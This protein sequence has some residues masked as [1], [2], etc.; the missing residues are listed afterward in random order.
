MKDKAGLSNALLDII[1][2]VALVLKKYS[3]EIVF[4]NELAKQMGAIAGK[5]CFEAICKSDTACNFCKTSD[6]W[7]SGEKQRVETEYAGKFWEFVWLPYNDDL[8]LHYLFDRTD[9]RWAEEKLRRSETT[10][11]TL[12][13]LPNAA[14]FLLDRNGICLDTNETLAR[15]LSRNRMEI[16]GKP[17]WDFFPQEVAERRKAHFEQVLIEKKQ[18]RFVDE[19]QGMWNESVISPILDDNGD[20]DVV[21]VFGFDITELKKVELMLRE[22]EEKF[23]VLFENAKDGILV[24]S[25]QGNIVA[26]NTAFARMHGYT[27]E[28]MM[29]LNLKDLDTPESARLAP[30]RIQQLL[31]GEPM[32]FE[33]EH[34]CKNGQTIFLETSA[35]MV[36]FNG[37]KHLYGFHRDIT[38]RKN[39]EA[40]LQEHRT[41][42]ESLVLKRT[43][44]LEET[45]AA[46]KVLLKHRESDKMEFEEKITSNVKLLLM[47]HIEKAKKASSK[48]DIEV[49]LKILESN[50][51][52]LI[53]SFALALS[54]THIGL[55]PKEI[56]IAGM[57][58]DGY[59]NKEIAEALNL[60]V[61]TVK[62]HRT[63]IRK[64]LGITGKHVNL[65]SFLSSITK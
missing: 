7:G 24:T 63:N 36:K 51:K 40:E 35:C 23:R 62:V 27:I 58:R 46:L 10:A 25:S 64:K 47:P 15:R 34:Y 22:S 18:V 17:I 42:L 21:T 44:E 65:M 53:S 45:N 41:N 20:V 26:L 37:E 57:V 43:A 61:Y 3:N 49:H 38:G 30:S 52:E 19:R 28:E 39:I 14:G 56:T 6:L 54:S 9:Q 48:H 32:T 55:A 33:V 1:P 31:T 8:C 12:L 11:R 59:Q 5:T 4:C 60:S 13:D 50:I 16:I 29:N 2:G